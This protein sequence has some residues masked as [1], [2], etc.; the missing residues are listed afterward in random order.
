MM[1]TKKLLKT[2]TNH[3]TFHPGVDSKTNKTSGEEKYLQFFF[4]TLLLY[5]IVSFNF[6]QPKSFGNLRMLDK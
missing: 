3:K 1:H 4:L 6:C 2:F 5:I